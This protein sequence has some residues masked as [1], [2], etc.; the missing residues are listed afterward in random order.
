MQ[1]KINSSSHSIALH[2]RDL[3]LRKEQF[4]NK[5][6]SSEESKYLQLI[7]FSLGGEDYAIELMYLQEVL[8]NQSVIRVPGSPFYLKGILNLRGKIVT[9]VDLRKRLGF[10]DQEEQNLMRIIIVLV[11]ERSI[12]LLVDEVNEIFQIAKK[13][14]IPPPQGLSTIN[15]KFIK[16]LGKKTEESTIIIPNLE[17]ILS[18]DSSPDSSTG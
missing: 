17:Q 6:Q 11:K 3:L 15:R 16:N 2:H 4:Y 14:I 18:F 1:E 13:Q 7:S 5:T 8:K 9:I 10:P 12:G